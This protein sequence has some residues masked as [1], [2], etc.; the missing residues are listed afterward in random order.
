MMQVRSRYYVKVVGHMTQR[1][2]RIAMVCPNGF[3]RAGVQY[4]ASGS[5][6]KELVEASVL[7]DKSR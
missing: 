5:R 3:N 1:F 6:I 7:W 2:G 4:S